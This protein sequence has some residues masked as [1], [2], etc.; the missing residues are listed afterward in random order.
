MSDFSEE[1]ISYGLKSTK[2]RQEI[3][4][5]LVDSVQPLTADQIYLQLNRNGGTMN[6]STIY[7]TLSVLSDKDILSKL[8]LADEGKTL[9]EYNRQVHKHYLVCQD[10]RTI[11][12]IEHCPIADYEKEVSKEKQFH[13]IGHK[14]SIYGYCQSCWQKRNKTTLD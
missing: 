13:I 1:L 11:I 3:L 7:R 9:Y 5:V 12:P 10:C 6:L 14:L 4:Q 2:N 8:V